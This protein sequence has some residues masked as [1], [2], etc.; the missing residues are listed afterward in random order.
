MQRTTKACLKTLL[1][2]C[3]KPASAFEGFAAAVEGLVS[4]FPRL[5]SALKA[6]LPHLIWPVW[7]HIVGRHRSQ[8]KCWFPSLCIKTEKRTPLRTDLNGGK[9][10]ETPLLLKFTPG[11]KVSECFAKSN[12]N[13]A[14]AHFRE[15]SP[16]PHKN[17]QKC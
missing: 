4:E 5:V 13:L 15:K 16:N 7:A 12:E 11:G 8:Q 3:T 14:F 10:K 6:W 2:S 17:M 1:D 9:H